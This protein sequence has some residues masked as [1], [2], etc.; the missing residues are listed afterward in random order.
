VA[1]GDRE[2]HPVSQRSGAKRRYVVQ[3]FFTSAIRVNEV[4]ESFLGSWCDACPAEDRSFV[5]R[6]AQAFEIG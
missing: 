6:V 1:V 3:Y 4:F 2:R 5:R